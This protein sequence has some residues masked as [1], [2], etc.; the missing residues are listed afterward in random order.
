MLLFEERQE[1]VTYGKKMFSS[2]LVKGS[3]GNISLCNPGKSL[4]AIT[5]TGVSYEEM[6]PEDVVVMDLDGGQAHGFLKPSS[7]IAFHLALIKLRPD[8]HA[9]VHTHSEYATTMA[10]LRWELPAVHYLVGSAGFQVPVSEYAT[11]GTQALS[12]NVCKA[13]GDGNAVLMANHGVVAV[14]TDLKSAFATAEMVE[15]VSKIYLQAKA[16]GDPHILDTEEM[17]IILEKFKNYGKQS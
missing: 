17:A 8:I 1:V 12:D 16:V 5:P 7:E 6:R 4:L 13:I 3:G 14:G 2:G 15:Y 10:C 11:F 9:V